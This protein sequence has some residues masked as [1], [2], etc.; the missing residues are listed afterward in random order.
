MLNRLEELEGAVRAGALPTEINAPEDSQF[1]A[2]SKGR[3]FLAE[4]DTP[5]TIVDNYV[6]A[7]TLD[8]LRDVQ[9]PIRLL[10]GRCGR[11]NPTIRPFAA[12]LDRW[13]HL[14]DG[15]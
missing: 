13:A 9:R 8:C 5:L 1:T 6:G 10:T 2:K 12:Y 4:A 7:G 3:E 11:F 15:K 14:L